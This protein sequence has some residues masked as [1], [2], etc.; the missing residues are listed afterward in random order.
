ME[1]DFTQ[2]GHSACAVDS[3]S[4][5]S[6]AKLSFRGDKVSD[7]VESDAKSIPEAL[8]REDGS[9]SLPLINISTEYSNLFIS[10]K[11]TGEVSAITINELMAKVQNT[12]ERAVVV[13]EYNTLMSAPEI[14][15]RCSQTGIRASVGLKINLVFQN[16]QGYIA[17]I[18]KNYEAFITVGKLLYH[19]TEN[20]KSGA[21]TITMTDLERFFG[22]HDNVIITTCSMN[23]LVSRLLL[24][25]QDEHVSV[26][27]KRFGMIFGDGNVF[28]EVQYHGDDAERE[29]YPRLSRIADSLNIPLLAANDPYF[30]SDTD[31]D[32]LTYNILK[33][34]VEHR[35]SDL[36]DSDKQ[37]YIKTPDELKAALKAI[38]TDEQCDRAI[39]GIALMASQYDVKCSSTPHY[40][41]YKSDDNTPAPELLRKMVSDSIPHRI[42]KWTSEYEERLNRELD[43]ITE[44]GFCDYLLIVADIVAFAKRE[45][46]RISRINCLPAGPGRGSAVGSLVC[47]LLGIT[48]IDPVVHGLMFERFLSPGRTAMPDIDVDVA[49]FV[50][51]NV[52]R[53]IKDKYGHKAVCGIRHAVSYGEK[54]SAALAAKYLS[55]ASVTLDP[56]SRSSLS[57]AKLS[58]R[59][60]KVTD[61]EELGAKLT[62]EALRRKLSGAVTHLTTHPCGVVISDSDDISDYIPVVHSGGSLVAACDKKYIESFYGLLKIDLLS[63]PT[64]DMISGVLANVAAHEHTTIDFS[65]IPEEHEVFEKIFHEGHTDF[66]FQFESS[67]MQEW[68]RKIHPMNIGELT[69]LCAAY[70]PGPMQFLPTVRD[71]I[72]D[73]KAPEYL[74]PKLMPILSETCG[75][76]IYQEQLL[77]ILTDIAGYTPEE[78]DRIRAAV[79][80]KNQEVI[81][82]E[83]ERF[84]NGCMRN[85][86]SQETAGKLYGQTVAFG[87]YAFNKSH[88][89]AYAVLAY[90]MAWLF[91]HYPKYFLASAFAHSDKKKKAGT[92]YKECRR[93]GIKL[94]PPDVNRSQSRERACEEGI[95]IGFSSIK[96]CGGIGDKITE[97]RKRRGAGYCD[98]ADFLVRIRPNETVLRNLALCGALDSLG[99]TRSAVDKNC[100]EILRLLEEIVSKTHRLEGETSKTKVNEIGQEINDCKEKIIALSAAADTTNM[101]ALIK[102]EQELMGLPLSFDKMRDYDASGR[103]RR[104]TTVKNMKP[105]KHRICGMV[106]EY[107]EF[108]RKKDKAL[109]CNITL[110]DETGMVECVL[111]TYCFQKYEGF[112]SEGECVCLEGEYKK[113]KE[114]FVFWI[115]AV[116]ELEENSMAYFLPFEGFSDWL[117]AQSVIRKYYNYPIANLYISIGGG[118]WTKA[119]FKVSPEIVSDFPMIAAG[120]SL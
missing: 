26:L 17:L 53:Y 9:G 89:A 100:G 23:G 43:T 27:L 115:K 117:T 12:G 88:A 71:V 86:L 40:P 57:D 90:R 101:S 79:C 14:L 32:M 73:E 91:Y 44:L 98:L 116:S 13:T 38:L 47:Y 76:L 58:C 114:G 19:S 1:H 66:I 22:G 10:Q 75:C 28:A 80:K 6:D 87:S 104:T 109:F 81:D 59:G 92:F 56:C 15:T 20:T 111:P 83:Q 25:N 84:V 96:G 74:T 45:G 78:A 37:H 108:H 70:R 34:G 54:D 106:V 35:Y 62:A 49:P 110:E 95:R 3:R 105:G 46:R 63:L 64:L 51:E 55:A 94:L 82:G 61:A 97:D 113:G 16:C 5:L 69:L 33:Y 68:L 52:L 7:A 99:V 30:V 67:G 21:P 93:C 4:T 42:G 50:R 112:L 39:K 120:E 72:Y 77:K 41:K 119:P 85:G 11:Q 18:P 29:I 24:E 118:E 36:S 65:A 102:A 48:D 8:R 31:K 107:K 103:S 2:F 60:D